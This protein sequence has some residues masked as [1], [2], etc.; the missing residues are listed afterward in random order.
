MLAAA[1]FLTPVLRAQTPPPAVDTGLLTETQLSA[2]AD[3]PVSRNIVLPLRYQMQA[4]DGYYKENQDTF[5]LSQALIPFVLDDDWALITRTDFPLVSQP[6]KKKDDQWA[7]G[8][9]NSYTTFF[10]SPEHVGS[11][12]GGIGPVLYYPTA[13]RSAI[14]VN[15][16]GSGPSLG[17]VYKPDPSWQFAVVV[18]NIW[19]FGGPPHGSDRKNSLLLNPMASYYF[20]DGWSISTSP[21][22]TSD[23]L[24][25]PGEQW[26]VPIGGGLSKTFHIAHDGLKLSLDAYYNTVRPQPDHDTWL[27][28]ITLTLVLPK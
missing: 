8:L 10:L 26:T 2:E 11:L 14:G 16:W 3:N 24:S 6:P 25:R 12:F 17:I 18:N 20:G 19:S 13:T 23:W 1:W 9:E 27:A 15:K 5:K 28:Q 7:T 21:N 4:D 22:I